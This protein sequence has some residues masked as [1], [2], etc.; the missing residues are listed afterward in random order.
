MAER[1]RITCEDGL[2]DCGDRCGGGKGIASLCDH[3][4][5]GPVWRR[6]PSGIYASAD[7][8]IATKL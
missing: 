8:E 1:A 6:R 5:S 7:S 3:D 2:F 4:V